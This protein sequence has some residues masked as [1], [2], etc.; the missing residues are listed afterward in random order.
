MAIRGAVDEEWNEY[1]ARMPLVRGFKFGLV[2]AACYSCFAILSIFIYF[3]T[4]ALFGRAPINEIGSAA[5]G[6]MWIIPAYFVGFAVAGMFFACASHVSNRVLRF[7]LVGL[8]CG[9]S[10]YGAVGISISFLDGKP[11]DAAEIASTA[12]GLGLLFGFLGL[13]MGCLD[14]WRERRRT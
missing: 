8:L 12:A 13:V 14:T 6:L 5:R 9:T 1:I 2:V 11:F 7:T 4:R 3:V 10:I